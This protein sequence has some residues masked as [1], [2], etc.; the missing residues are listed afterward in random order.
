MAAANSLASPMGKVLQSKLI[1]SSISHSKPVSPLP[2]LVH[3][4]MIGLAI[5]SY[6]N[7]WNMLDCIKQQ[8]CTQQGWRCMLLIGDQPTFSRMWD[9][10][11]CHPEKHQWL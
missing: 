7:I 9:I 3:A 10:K 4:P 6:S 8:L 1:Q 11:V 2:F 5:Q